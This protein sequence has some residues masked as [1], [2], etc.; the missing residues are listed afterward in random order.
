MV[1]RF[2]VVFYLILFFISSNVSWCQQNTDAVRSTPID[3]DIFKLE[4]KKQLEPKTVYNDLINCYTKPFGDMY[5]RPTNVHET[6]HGVNST[7]SNLK[8]GYRAFYC[9]HCRAIW[10]KEPNITMQDIIPNIPDILKDYRYSLYFIS[11]LKYW[12]NVGL[13]PVDEW[14]AYIAGAECAVEDHQNQIKT[15]EKAD[16]VSGTLEFS[17][18]CTALAKTVKEKDKEYWDNYP[19]FKNSIQF[20]LIKS[21]KVFFDGRYI[22]PSE[23]QEVLLKNLQ[24]HD[25]ANS[26]RDFLKTEFNGVFIE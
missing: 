2:K 17:I 25:D 16:S 13:Y 19:Q 22:F 24:E 7:L 20:F 10:L 1:T 26:I 3:I 4:Q 23:R 9:G 18:Y 14:S 8:N 15:K 6:V 11:Q 21:E 5:G 12:N